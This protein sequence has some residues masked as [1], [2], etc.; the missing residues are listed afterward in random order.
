MNLL[1]RLFRITPFKLSLSITLV[2]LTGSLI[3]DFNPSKV[4][5]IQAID[6]KSLDLKFHL[7]GAQASP[8][9][10]VILAADEK[11][12]QTFG[13]WPFDRGTIFAPMLREL[14]KLN[15]KVVGLDLV[16]TDRE[17]LIAPKLKSQLAERL[18]ASA[19]DLDGMIAGS[20]G[21]QQIREAVEDCKNKIVLGYAPT[22]NASDGLSETELK[23]RVEILTTQGGNAMLSRRTGRLKFARFR[24]DR[25]AN[26]SFSYNANGGQFNTADITPFGVA[27]G[28]MNNEDDGDGSYRHGLMF[29]RVADT[30]VPSLSLRMAQKFLSPNDEPPGISIVPNAPEQGM[31]ESL[32]LTIKTAEGPRTVPIDLHAQTLVNYRGPNYTYPNVSLADLLSGKDKIPYVQYIPGVGAQNFEGSK[33]DLF[34]QALVLVGVTAMSLYDIRPRPLEE[35]AAGV[36]NHANILDNL[37]NDDF[38]KRPSAEN[39]LIV[40]MAIFV[41]SL[42]YGILINRLN[43]ALG[44][45]FAGLV[46]SGMVY[47]DQVIL[48]NR[49]NI[50]FSGYLQAMQFLFQFI[51]ITIFKYMREENEKKFIR[52]AFDKYV[53]P[54][55]VDSMLKDPKKLKLGGEKIDLSIL[56]SDIRGFTELSEKVDVKQ[57]TSFLNEYLGAMTEILQANQ[58]TLDK[59]IGDAV[60]GFWGAPVENTN[61]AMCAVKTAIEMVA[62]LDELNKSF[63]EKYGFTIDIGIGINSGAVSVGNFG[64]NKVFE[65]TVIGDNVNLASRLEGVTKYYGAKIVISDTTHAALKPGAFATRE[66]DTVRVKGKHKPVKIYEVLPDA[67]AFQGVRSGLEHFNSGL[68]NYY[69]QNWEQAIDRLE[70]VLKVK[71]DDRPTLELIERCKHYKNNPP[72]QDW[73]GSWEMTSK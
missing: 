69:A 46:I 51:A 27:Q 31:T 24:A 63:K 39:F 60:M 18:G 2:F 45:L 7:R 73:D 15:T 37:I 26:V 34:D 48:F 14:C 55:V 40:M 67:P 23:K 62:K 11:A 1:K 8:S 42:V 54:A 21:D 71:K 70:A 43:A 44:A 50:V 56:F 3:H 12:F 61:H 36:E 10:I 38:L 52:S 4:P 30:F 33:K 59:Y 35:I 29:F 32:T 13:Q 25:E 22:R 5:F 49:N 6:Q 19:A 41:A 53:S 64:S 17:K 28:F 16:W 65:Y 68:S 66:I 58:G 57:L 9:K 47:F 20:S 72:A